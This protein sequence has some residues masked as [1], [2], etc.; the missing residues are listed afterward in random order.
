MEQEILY[1]STD[2]LLWICYI[3]TD[4]LHLSVTIDVDLA[5]IVEVLQDMVRY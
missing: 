3:Y 5:S 1:V 4:K 2:N